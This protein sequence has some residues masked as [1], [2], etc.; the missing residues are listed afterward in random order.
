MTSVAAPKL[1]DRVAG[2][3]IDS[4]SML[5]TDHF[6]NVIMLFSVRSDFANILDEIDQR[7]FMSYPEHFPASGL[8]YVLLAVE[9]HEQLSQETRSIFEQKVD[10]IKMLIESARFRLR[11]LLDAREMGR[12]VEMSKR[13]VHELRHL[14]EGGG[15]IVHGFDACDQHGVVPQSFEAWSH[16]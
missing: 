10:E 1:R 13:I 15:A 12:L 14:I 5:S 2:T 3:N 6:N 8:A 16:I 4:R 11:L 9:C 7:Q